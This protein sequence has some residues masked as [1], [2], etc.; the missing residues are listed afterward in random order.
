[1]ASSLQAR[2]QVI[3]LAT[4]AS[5]DL[6]SL[7][8]SGLSPLQ[9]REAL[10]RALPVLASEY[11]SAASAIS[12]D[13]YDDLRSSKRLKRRFR[14]VPAILPTPERFES[15][16][17]WAVEPMFRL[18]LDGNP[19][20]DAVET[21]VSK[22]SGGLQ[23]II[24]NA[25]RETVT[26]STLLDPEAAGW[27]R[28]GTGHTCKFCQMLLSRGA[29]YSAETVRF[30]SHDN[31]NCAASPSWDRSVKVET[32]EPFVPSKRRRS[33]QTK[34]LDAARAKEFIAEMD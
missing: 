2:Q 23:R 7:K 11:G 15:L 24:L 6:A 9:V 13:W 14:A 12:A 31:C 21:T 32:K 20:V 25:Q 18:D 27:A 4:L 3:D 16:A 10:A 8:L 5:D 34:S 22:A 17:G 26:R 33:A 28:V 29:V 30:R 1:M 19:P